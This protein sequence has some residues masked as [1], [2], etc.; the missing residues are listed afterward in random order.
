MIYVLC[1]LLFIVVIGMSWVVDRSDTGFVFICGLLVA[2]LGI[3]IGMISV[4]NRAYE[5]G[6][7]DHHNGKVTMQYNYKMLPDSTFV[8]IDTLIQKK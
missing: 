7:K 5:N 6:V 2:L 1:V 8:P 4:T 3:I